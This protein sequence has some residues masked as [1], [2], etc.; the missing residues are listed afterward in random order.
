VTN[1]LRET[2][3]HLEFA[4]D[5]KSSRLHPIGYWLLD[6][7]LLYKLPL[8]EAVLFPT[9]ASLPNKPWVHTHQH[10]Y[11]SFSV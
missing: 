6:S 10:N 2:V 5:L 7:S 9:L 8:N 4:A 1:V 3:L 11:A